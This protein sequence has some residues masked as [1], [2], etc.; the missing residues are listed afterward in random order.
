MAKLSL[1]LDPRQM[2]TGAE[3]AENAM[4]GV[5]RK[6]HKTESAVERLGRD[7]GQALDRMGSAA[8]RAGRNAQTSMGGLRRAM[9]STTA[10]LNLGAGAAQNLGFQ[11]GDMATQIGAGTA[12]SVAMGQQLPQLIQG[13]GTVGALMGAVVAIAIP[14]GAALLSAGADSE[15]MAKQL[16]EL[17]ES[18]QNVETALANASGENVDRLIEKFGRMRVSV[19]ELVQAQSE[20][21]LEKAAR[22]LRDAR[23]ALAE[24]L[25][26]GLISGL[27][28]KLFGQG[29]VARL[30]QL[31]RELGL[32]RQEA[33]QLKSALDNLDTVEGTEES[34][35]ALQTLA[36]VFT[37]I[38][39]GVENLSDEELQFVD[40]IYKAQSATEQFLNLQEQSVQIFQDIEAAIQG[41]QD[42]MDDVVSKLGGAVDQSDA[43]ALSTSNIDLSGVLGQADTLIRKFS[44]AFATFRALAAEV[45]AAGSRAETE[46]QRIRLQEIELKGLRSGASKVQIA[47]EL[48][49][50][51][52]RNRLGT[53]RDT[54]FSGVIKDALVEAARER[55]EAFARN[56]EA[57][58]ALRRTTT[59][60]S[61]GSAADID[62]TA[63]AYD[64]LMASLDPTI[65]AMQNLEVAQKTINDA[66]AAGL[67]PEEAARAHELAREQYDK[68]IESAQNAS[69]KLG[70]IAGET[71][72]AIDGLFDI[73]IG[74]GGDAVDIL[75]NLAAQFLKMAL[76]QGLKGAF[77]GLGRLL[78]FDGGGFT[79]AGPRS[80]GVDGK[81]GILSIVHPNETVFDHEKGQFP[82]IQP[83]IITAPANTNSPNG[84]TVVQIINNAPGVEVRERRQT[85]PDG[86]KVLVAEINKAATRGEMSGFE[87]RYGLKSSKV[88]R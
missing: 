42:A 77:P 68:T 53:V 78:S 35:A 60:G 61:R 75:E 86:R 71:R 19:L 1:A 25:D 26:G 55:G 64:R 85:G 23:E 8:Q 57:L 79:G 18:L 83:M 22:E 27:V 52:E 73:I 47:G 31:S 16:D 29:E 80:G 13:F 5:A 24:S 3:R 74:K 32:S 63:Q 4:D 39:G 59:G 54:G 76:F 46:E 15:A 58:A 6:A 70:D 20:I 14:L 11:V 44:T 48:A 84:G 12:A 34:A 72:S 37:E 81:G 40:N 45:G 69:G 9:R 38:R 67:D 62:K 82:P 56:Q 21:A 28:F 36:N 7:G 43:L 65:R 50:E 33:E 49:A 2:E 30:A 87:S 10:R 41:Q 17:E 51:R 66:M 88:A